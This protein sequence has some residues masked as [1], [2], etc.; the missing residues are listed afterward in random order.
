MRHGAHLLLADANPNS[1][2]SRELWPRYQQLLPHTLHGMGGIGKSRIA[3]EY[4]NRHTAD[5]A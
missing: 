4:V 3:I 5:H 2:G 1:P